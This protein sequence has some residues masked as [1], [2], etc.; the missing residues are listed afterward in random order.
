MHQFQR[1]PNRSLKSQNPKRRLIKLHILARRMM[2][3]M[4]R[5]D[6]IDG[7]SA[8]PAINASLSARDASGGFIL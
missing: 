5:R 4:I 1:Q 6:A 2:R 3:R 7:P 8:S